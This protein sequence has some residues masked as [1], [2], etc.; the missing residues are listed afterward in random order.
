MTTIMEYTLPANAADAMEYRVNKANRKAVLL[1][2]ALYRLEIEPAEP[3]RHHELDGEV[4]F[5]QMINVRVIGDAPRVGDYEVAGVITMDPIAGMVPNLTEGVLT[6]A[7]IE[8][9]RLDQQCDHCHSNRER[10]KIFILKGADG[11]VVQVGS[12]CVELYT[13]VT[14]NP[15]EN[16]H[17]KLREEIEDEVGLAVWGIRAYQITTVLAVA[18]HII[19]RHGYVSARDA[20]LNKT[21]STG[22]RVRGIVAS[23]QPIP[24]PVVAPILADADMKE[25]EDTITWARTMDG[26]T[27]YG[28]KVAAIMKQDVCSYESIGIVASLVMS[29]RRHLD[30]QA[31]E[32]LK[33]T[34]QYIGTKDTRHQFGT[35]KV[36]S[37][38]FFDNCYGGYFLVKMVDE[39]GSLIVWKPKSASVLRGQRYTL[40]ARIKLHDE[41]QGTKQTTV[42]HVKLTDA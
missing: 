29:Y 12:A 5:E 2:Q 11:Q 21:M 41:W 14:V 32:A 10:T 3:I 19:D 27:E 42:T 15:V 31:L 28:A 8:A 7:E 4:W 22:S 36:L 24:V 37:V 33:T 23:R 35:V 30:R 20:D 25:V 39:A 17:R 40:V 9:V 13:G 16:F 34:S 38:R 18:A 6:S 26:D 1:G